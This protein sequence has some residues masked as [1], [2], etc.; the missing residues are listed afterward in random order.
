MLTSARYG[1]DKFV[2]VGGYQVHYFEIGAGDPVLLIAGSYS[3]YRAWNR[4]I[5]LL[6][7]QY[8]LLALD[9]LGAGDSDKPQ[10]GFCY[11]VQE[12]AGF[13]S[14]LIKQ[15]NLGRV[16]LVGASYG[17]A[18]VLYL[19]ARYP[20]LVNKVVSIEGGIVKP[21]AMPGSPMEFA[22]K[23]PVIGDLFIGLV[24][25][26]VLNAFLLKL[27]AGQWYAHMS[28]DDRRELLEQLHYNA[29]SA[30]RISWYWISVSYKTCE[31]FSTAAKTIQ[32][33]LLY[34]YGT[35]SDFME[36]LL[37][38][39]IGFIKTHLH[40]A[41]IVGLAGGIHDLQFQKPTEVAGLILDFL[42]KPHNPGPEAA[43][44]CPPGAGD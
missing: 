5:P 36:P 38:D 16:H 1:D 13:I 30:T 37:Q 32:M 6:S 23:Y 27:I 42:Q 33:P 15:L 39:N 11:S 8:R 18:I 7:K 31:D 25:T 19:A 10:K 21:Q 41:Q 40:H 44:K 22:L 14:R 4:V 20:E 34:L 28:L 9:Y 43:L 2:D 12:Q 3:T 35:A 26:G 17:G 24:K 29:R